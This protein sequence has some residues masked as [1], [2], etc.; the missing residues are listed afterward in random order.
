MNATTSKR[1]QM[2]AAMK[3]ELDIMNADLQGIEAG[4]K[5]LTGQAR[6]AADEKLDALRKHAS[7]A[8]TKLDELGAAAEDRWEG[9]TV[10]AARIRDAFSHS[11]N[12]L[13]SQLKK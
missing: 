3:K 13:K 6:V 7:A 5:E 4:A 2:I 9:L 11:Y 1:E 8:N 10:E 12:Y